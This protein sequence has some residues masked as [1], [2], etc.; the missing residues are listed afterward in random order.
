MKK[1]LLTVIITI[2]CLIIASCGDSS[3]NGTQNSPSK[4]DPSKN[5]P[6]GAVALTENNLDD[7]FD[8]KV[9]TELNYNGYTYSTTATTYVSFVPKGEYSEVSGEVCFDI[10]TRIKQ[11]I[12]GNFETKVAQLEERILLLAPLNN[13]SHVLGVN[14]GSGT[15]NDPSF[16]VVSGTDNITVKSVYGYIIPGE[17]EQNEYESITDEEK[18][19]SDEVLSELA[20]LVSSFETA[21]RQSKSHSISSATVYKLGSL[22]GSGL[23]VNRTST[24]ASHRIDIGNG[25]FTYNED[26]CYRTGDEYVREYLNSFDLVETDASPYTLDFVLEQAEA[27]FSL[28]D[29]SAIYVKNTDSSY[30]GYTTLSA[31]K[32]SFVKEQL[33]KLLDEYGVTGKYNEFVVKYSFSFEE[34]AFYFNAKIDHLDYNYHVHFVDIDVTFYQNITELN[35]CT[36]E[37]YS[38]AGHKAALSDNKEDAVRFKSGLVE[39]DE[40]TDLIY[41]STLGKSYPGYTRP[42]QENFLPIHIKEGGVYKFKGDYSYIYDSTGRSFDEDYFTAG[43][44]F[45]ELSNVVYGVTN[46]VLEVSCDIYEDYGKLTDPTPLGA[47]GSFVA[48]LEAHADRV[49][50]SF[51]PDKSGMYEFPVMSNVNIYAYYADDIEH[52]F[53][54]IPNS[55]PSVY[56]EEGIA[57]VFAFVYEVYGEE[58]DPT[59]THSGKLEFIGDPP[60]E[61]AVVGKEPSEIFVRSDT[62]YLNF[63]VDALGEYTVNIDHIRGWSDPSFTVTPYDPK[64]KIDYDLIRYVDGRPIYTLTPGKYVIDISMNPNA[65]LVANVSVVTVTEGVDE[66][67]EAVITD[68][69]TLVR[70]STLTTILS[71]SRTYFTVDDTSVLTSLA[72]SSFYTLYSEDGTR[73]GSAG[74][75]SKSYELEAGRYYILFERTVYTTVYDFEATFT[76]VKKG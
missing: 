43:I 49:V 8:I 6:D 46:R 2:V 4:D 61:I 64:D 32:N 51:T 19:L 50:F 52:Y 70:S 37:L 12:T 27:E 41:F 35:S 20:E 38:E 58:D 73:L 18:A 57:Y 47:D 28:F 44:Y 25:R 62:A 66:V 9:R 59:V 67:K 1:I 23:S 21:Y 72:G 34:G 39:I 13:T 71:K 60:T 65:Y 45:L 63:T 15:L 7:Y 55:F 36:I 74:Q 14:G 56:L 3:D 69:P 75:Y 30:F 10:N 53:I 31:M 40:T 42:D 54:F 48:R 29:S 33:I 68:E 16:M 76:L 17:K 5:Y 22:Y 26:I 24:L 11:N